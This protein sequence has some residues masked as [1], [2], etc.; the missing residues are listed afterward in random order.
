MSALDWIA[1]QDPSWAGLPD[2]DRAE[3]ADF[4]FLWTFFEGNNPFGEN[5]GKALASIAKELADAGAI[6][7]QSLAPALEYFRH[8]YFRDGKFTDHYP[9]LNLRK[10]DNVET[11]NAVLESK[12]N[13]PQSILT[14]LLTIA[15]RFRNNLFHG[16][17]WAYGLQGQQENF[18]TA[19]AVLMSTTAML[20]KA[21]GY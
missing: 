21:R 15:Y 8:R 2:A 4:V 11:V 17:K 12:D 18:Q 3:I 14:A 10:S 5:A 16:L 9:H 20:N 19:S 6:D 13:S 1:K 7:L